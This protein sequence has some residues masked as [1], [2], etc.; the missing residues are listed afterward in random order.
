MNLNINLPSL[1]TV[2]RI[3]LFLQ[4]ILLTISLI[5]F[6]GC[7]KSSPTAPAPVA[8]PEPQEVTVTAKFSNHTRGYRGETTYTGKPGDALLITVSDSGAT[9]VDPDRI[10]LREAANGGMIGEYVDFS[11]D[12]EINV[13]FPSSDAIY[14]VFLMNASNGADYNDI[15]YWVDRYGGSLRYARDLT[16]HREDK[17]GY[18]GM[19]SLINN[20]VAQ[21]NSVIQRRFITYGTITRVPSGGD[22]GI[23][24]GYCGG[25]LGVHGTDNWAGVNPNNCGKNDI[26]MQRVFIAE[27]YELLIGVADL[28]GGKASYPYITSKTGSL[29]PFA[30]DLFAYVYVKNKWY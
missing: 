4:V 12:G 15:D 5:S 24:Y 26:L 3:I 29:M 19:Q 28:G 23:G 6:P 27:I 11:R 7:K 30:K 18:S 13:T 14:D 2:G 16:Y 8:E 22:I 9:D 1:S 10:V 20:A 17:D 21:L 25:Y